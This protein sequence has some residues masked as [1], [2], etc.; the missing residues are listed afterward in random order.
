[1]VWTVAAVL[2]SV[3]IGISANIDNMGIGLSYSMRRSHVS[4][5]F[6]S[7]VALT[8]FVAFAVGGLT[9]IRLGHG[10][11]VHLCNLLGSAVFICL[12]L[13]TIVQTLFSSVEKVSPDIR[14]GFS[15]MMFIALA[16][17]LTDL[18][19]GFGAGF[20]KLSVL[21]IAVFVGLFSFLF[22]LIPVRFDVRFIPRKLSMRATVCSGLLLIVVGIFV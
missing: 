7:L 22:L 12:G 14:I 17:G 18:S 9:A 8:S 20:A 13:W 21:S 2:L 15:E 10:V 1:M 3:L 16:Q 19:V 5:I 6:C 4:W 11:P